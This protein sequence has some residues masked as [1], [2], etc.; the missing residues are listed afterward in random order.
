MGESPMQ[1]LIGNQ[2][3]EMEVA[4]H[5]EMQAADIGQVDAAHLEDERGEECDQ[6]DDQQILCDGRYAEHHKIDDLLSYDFEFT[7]CNLHLYYL[8][9][10]NTKNISFLAPK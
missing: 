10:K 8:R 6:V 2:L 1:E 5:K 4:G 9:C 7:I 3:I